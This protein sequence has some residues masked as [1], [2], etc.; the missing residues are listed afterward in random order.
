MWLIHVHYIVCPNESGGSTFFFLIPPLVSVNHSMGIP[1]MRARVL[2]RVQGWPRFVR[3]ALWN[4]PLQ[5]FTNLTGQPAGR[6]AAEYTTR[7]DSDSFTVSCWLKV[8]HIFIQKKNRKKDFIFLRLK[9][10]SY[11]KYLFRI[12]DFCFNYI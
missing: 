8:R 10:T 9:R 6:A 12:L 2:S 1:L 7:W 11:R 4:E 3:A 5:V